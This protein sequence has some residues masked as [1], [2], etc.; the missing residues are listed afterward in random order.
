[1]VIILLPLLAVEAFKAAADPTRFPEQL[2]Y[3]QVWKAERIFW[4]M[5]RPKEE[6]VKD[7]P[8]ITSVDIGAFNPLLGKSYGEL[9]SRKQKHAQ[10][11][12]IRNSP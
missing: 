10:K 9:A 7:K 4:N 2:K 5:F 1:M 12:G 8:D 6:E 3:V 11:S